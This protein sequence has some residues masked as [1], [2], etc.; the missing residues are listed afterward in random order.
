MRFFAASDQ[1]KD[2]T[3]NLP[4]GKRYH[5]L[6][7]GLDA[8]KMQAQSWT[9]EL[10]TPSRLIST[11]RRTRVSRVQRSQPTS[12][13]NPLPSRCRL[14]SLSIVVKDEIGFTADKMQ[15]LCYAL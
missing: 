6:C 4:P 12:K 13:F 8:D 10:R 5:V 7:T 2:R 15:N 11:F 3:G 14:T 9:Q 1:D